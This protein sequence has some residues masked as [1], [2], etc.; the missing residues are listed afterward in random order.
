MTTVASANSFHFV[1]DGGESKPL[2]DFPIISLQGKLTG[3]GLEDQ[4]P[5][6]AIVTHYDAYGVVP[7]LSHGVDSTASG[8]VALIEL[9]RIFSKLF[10]KSRTQ[11]KFNILF[12]LAGGGKF[13]YQGTKKWIED[14]VESSEISLLAEADY[15]LCIDSI[16]QG[17]GLNL[18]VSKPP[19]DGSQGFYLIEDL[20]HVATQL[21]PETTF[22][23]IHKKVNLADDLLAWEHERFSLRRLPAGTL[24]HLDKATPAKRGSIFDKKVNMETL[25]RNIKIISEGIARHLFNLSGKGYSDRLEVFSGNLAIDTDHIQS[26]LE[27]LSSQPRSQQIISKDHALLQGLEQ[28]LSNYLK[29]VKRLTA[30]AD[31]KDPDYIFYNVFEANMSVYSVKPALFDLFLAAGIAA[32]LGVVYLLLQNFHLIVDMLPKPTTN[33]NGRNL[34]SNGRGVH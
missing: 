24:S 1:T 33:N 4:L 31:K 16:G 19:R 22:N 5:T 27:H 34:M 28:Y 10:D 14:N 8:V 12:L 30:R 20:K 21:F 32:Y 9:A 17:E 23:I 3:Q 6:V 29:D 11:P 7:S 25:H 15:V 18:H 26:W 2:A 13:N